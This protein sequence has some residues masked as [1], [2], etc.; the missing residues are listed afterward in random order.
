[1]DDLA[2]GAR[3]RRHDAPPHEFPHRRLGAE[4]LTRE[5]DVEHLAPFGQG[6]RREGGIGLQPG[7]GDQD[8]DGAHR[9]D[10]GVEHGVYLILRGHV[11]LVG[12]RFAAGALD[13][14][15]H[16]VR[17]RFVVDIIDDDVGP[18]LAER[19]GDALAD[20]G[21]GPCHQRL[22]ATQNA[23]G[24]EGGRGR[25]RRVRIGGVRIGSHGVKFL[26]SG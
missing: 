1:M 22:L 5:V 3:H 19:D 23:L 17:G 20:A 15:D 14:G 18:G 11:G 24:R 12:H 6:H 25:A 13:R 4:E 16:L 8:V 2:G 26:A 21:I 7:I 9:A 10:R